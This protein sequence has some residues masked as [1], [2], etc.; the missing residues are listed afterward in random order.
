MQT[1]FAGHLCGRGPTQ[2]FM[3][4]LCVEYKVES[5]MCN[6][7]ILILIPN[8]AM[9]VESAEN[10]RLFFFFRSTTH[11]PSSAIHYQMFTPAMAY[12]AHHLCE[13]AVLHC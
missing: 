11:C 9:N 13:E 4:Y 2:G 1:E 7:E 5:R 3:V 10:E 8:G 6:F 12:N